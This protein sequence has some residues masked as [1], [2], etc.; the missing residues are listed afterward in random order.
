MILQATRP[1]R[2]TRGRQNQ[3]SYIQKY[4]TPLTN[5]KRER[6]VVGAQES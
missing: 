4:R 2:P 6:K 1:I 3:K 5:A